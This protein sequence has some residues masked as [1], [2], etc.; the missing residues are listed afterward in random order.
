MLIP[1]HATPGN[2]PAPLT[3]ARLFTGWTVD[4]LLLIGLVAAGALYLAGVVALA[5]RGDRW[6]VRRTVSF[7][8]GALGSAA[9]A[10]MSGLGTYDT[11]LFSVH[12]A[13]HMVLMM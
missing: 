2:Q 5:R 9:V 7:I 13:Q 4:W 6:P 8:V 10:T 3:A 12:M 1:L 11:V